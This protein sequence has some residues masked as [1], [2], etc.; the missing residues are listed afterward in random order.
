MKKLLLIFLKL[1]L[2]VLLLSLNLFKIDT[3]ALSV[4]QD[5]VGIYCIKDNGNRAVSEW[6]EI[7]FEGDNYLEYYYFDQ[8][9]YLLMKGFTPD[10]YIVNEKGQW[11][12]NGVVQ[13]KYYG[14]TTSQK[15]SYVT[16]ANT[17]NSKYNYDT[18]SNSYPNHSSIIMFFIILIVVIINFAR[19]ISKHIDDEDNS[20]NKYT[21]YPKHKNKSNTYYNNNDTTV[22]RSIWWHFRSDTDKRG[23]QGEDEVAERLKYIGNDFIVLRNINLPRKNKYPVQIDFLC[24]SN[25]G[26]YVIEVKNWLGTILG[27][28]DD[29]NW[30]SKIYDIDNIQKNP[31][32]QNEWHIDVLKRI[33]KRNISYY[34][35]I[36]FTDRANLNMLMRCYND[37]YITSINNLYSLINEIYETSNARIISNYKSIA[38]S[39]RK[40][41]IV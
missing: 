35:I 38:D 10:G 16:K 21:D 20:Y 17:N 37:S 1:I 12:V 36:A 24:V 41:E 31:I 29:E 11:I 7:D 14:K 4:N 13:K 2:F 15:K 34:S 22:D 8:Y 3:F 5:L 19:F 39:L 30:H 40:F 26:I 9:G 18:Y 25:K 28:Y 33:I 32:K 6:V 23:E 27:N